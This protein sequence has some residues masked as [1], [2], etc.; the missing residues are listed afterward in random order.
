M[1]RWKVFGD[2]RISFQSIERNRMMKKNKKRL[3]VLLV[4]VTML[5]GCTKYLADDDKKKIVNEV[6]GQALTSNI[7]CLPQD[8]DLIQIYEENKDNMDVDYDS[9]KPCADFTPGDLKYNGL[10]ETLFIKPLAFVIIKLGVLV[11]NYGLAVVLLGFLIRLILLPFTKKS[12]MQSE[13]MKKA[14]PELQA[15][16]KK[17]GQTNDQSTAMMM[18]QEMMMVYKKYNINPA[19]GC[20]VAFIQ[21][22]ILFAFLEAINRVPAIFEGNFLHLQ[23]G[24]SPFVGIKGGNFL[25]IILIV[26]IVLTT[27]FSLKNSMSSTATGNPEQDKQ[28]AMTVK[29]MIVFISIAS[30]SLPTALALYWIV[31]NGFVIIQNVAFKKMVAGSSNKKSSLDKNKKDAKRANFKKKGK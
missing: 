18:S 22:P 8:D 19:S 1:F 30:L 11:K 27:Y 9:L 25:Y 6:T 15:I 23:L 31:S 24:T 20:L 17:Y 29:F 7:L 2:E 10:W 21:L 3:V 5:T 14:Q 16:Q 28:M 12:M 26:L 13:N 4:L